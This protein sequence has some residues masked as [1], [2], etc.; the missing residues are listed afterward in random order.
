MDVVTT[1]LDGSLDS[2][3]YLK[4]PNGIYV[5]NANVGRNMYCTKLNKSLY[6]LK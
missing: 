3:I 1:Y 5:L 6:G 4:A 2:D